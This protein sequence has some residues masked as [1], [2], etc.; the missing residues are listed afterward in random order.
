MILTY[1][2]ISPGIWIINSTFN[3]ITG[4]YLSIFFKVIITQAEL[5]CST[6]FERLL[7]VKHKLVAIIGLQRNESYNLFHF[8]LDYL[9]ANSTMTF[10]VRTYF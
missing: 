9:L 3:C 2:T 6:R 4:Y 5:F 7:I 1:N 8:V 10:T